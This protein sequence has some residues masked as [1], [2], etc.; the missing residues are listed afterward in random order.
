MKDFFV[1]MSKGKMESENN[2]TSAN[3][4]KLHEKRK[5][6]IAKLT[7]EHK[8]NSANTS[9][10]SLEQASKEFR[11]KREVAMEFVKKMRREKSLLEQKREKYERCYAE[12]KRRLLEESEAE[13]SQRNESIR[14]KK[15]QDTINSYHL[16]R[17]KRLSQQIAWKEAQCKPM[18]R[19]DKY[20]HKRYEDKY[21]KEVLLPFLERRKSELIKRKE[22]LKIIT[23]KEL[24]A[25]IRDHNQI[26]EERKKIKEKEIEAR[27]EFERRS[28]KEQQRFE[29]KLLQQV[30]LMDRKRKEETASHEME[31]KKVN[32]RMMSY[33]NIVK[34]RIKLVPSKKLQASL[35]PVHVSTN[36]NTPTVNLK[37]RIDYLPELEK[38]RMEQSKELLKCDW[39]RYIADLK[40]S[41]EISFNRVYAKANL[42]EEHAKLQESALKH[43]KTPQQY[44]STEA[45]ATHLLVNSVKLKLAMLNKLCCYVT[46]SILLMAV[47]CCVNEILLLTGDQ[48][49]KEKTLK[50]ADYGL[51]EL[52]IPCSCQ[53][54]SYTHLTLPTI[55]SV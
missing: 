3:P 18:K 54:V 22:L 12:R 30:D 41:C 29:T 28:L 16:L 19:E 23:H 37:R 35:N 1:I 50:N 33:A 26:I 27:R 51:P 39:S 53:P 36:A 42:M 55:C 47:Q 44:L 24:A 4:I 45:K 38:K 9:I 15:V 34:A 7:S 49:S 5:I 46:H 20:V 17:N 31:R 8:S 32:R 2:L 10:H 48:F 13:A 52:V 14:V 6:K 43:S 11:R 25:Y 21:N 40:S